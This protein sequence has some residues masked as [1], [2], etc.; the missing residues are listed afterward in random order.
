MTD[1]AVAAAAMRY[2]AGKTDRDLP[3]ELAELTDDELRLV[4]HAAARALAAT[5]ITAPR[6]MDG[7]ESPNKLRP[8]CGLTA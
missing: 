3:A 2:V 4:V 8:R 1:P 7:I 5:D 6:Q